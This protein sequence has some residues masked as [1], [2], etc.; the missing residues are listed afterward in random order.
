MLAAQLRV[1]FLSQ[2]ADKNE[3]FR[4]SDDETIDEIVAKCG[5]C[6]ARHVEGEKLEFLIQASLDERQFRS[7]WNDANNSECPQCQ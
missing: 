1:H 4:M 2:G 3:V 6:G 5:W 7:N